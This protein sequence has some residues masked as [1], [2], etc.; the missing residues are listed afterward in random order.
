MHA[1][2]VGSTKDLPEYAEKGTLYF[3]DETCYLYEG[4][5]KDE[6]L[7]IVRKVSLFS[8]IKEFFKNNYHIIKNIKKELRRRKYGIY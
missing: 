8:K 7:K 6:G 2:H 3:C 1:I 5:G 4:M